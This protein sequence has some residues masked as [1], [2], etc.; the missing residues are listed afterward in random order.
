MEKEEIKK[1]LEKIQYCSQC[2]F[3]RLSEIY[4]NPDFEEEDQ[5]L[6]CVKLQRIVHDQMHWTDIAERNSRHSGIDRIP[7]D[8][9]FK[10]L[11]NQA[12]LMN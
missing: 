9:P 4:W 5:D 1:N 11:F 10:E 12:N 2:P 6:Y 7:E 8:C 3:C